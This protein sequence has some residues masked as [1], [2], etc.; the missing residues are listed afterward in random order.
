MKKYFLAILVCVFTSQA[1]GFVKDPIYDDLDGY[2]LIAAL[3]KDGKFDLAWDELKKSESKKKNR[4]RYQLLLG[5]YYY[6][7]G[8]WKKAVSALDDVGAGEFQS[9]AALVL[10]RAYYQLKS[11]EKCRGAY[12]AAPMVAAAVENDFIW[13]ATCEYKTKRY[14]EAWSALARAKAKFHSFVIEREMVGLKMDMG[15]GHEAFLQALDWFA[16]NQGF[17]GQYLDVAEQLHNRGLDDHA[18]AILETGRSLYPMHLDINLTLSQLYFQKNLLMASED[19][20]SRA[21]FSDAKYF[22]HAA[23]INRQLGRFERSQYFNSYVKDPKEKIKQKIA[24]YVDAGKFPLIASLESVLSRS[25]L[26]KDDEIRYALAYS[27]VKMGQ[28][29]EPL[30]Y[31][32]AI[33]KPELIEKTTVL[34]KTLIDCQ[35]KKEACRL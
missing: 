11:F 22:Y 25:D 33:T 28:I 30:K 23:E 19:G 34:R 16:V 24:S 27:L 13:L 14:P 7:K 32:S 31:L 5:H 6:G 35:E 29:E 3:I 17:P 12:A 8:E 26:S 18:I 1:F 2:D 9:Q 21:A 10:G 15:L 20:F 4:A